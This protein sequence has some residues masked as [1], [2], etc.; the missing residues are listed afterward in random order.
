MPKATSSPT[1]TLTLDEVIRRLAEHVAVDGLLL[2]GSASE[3]ALIPASD[4]DLVVAL[5]EMPVP[6]HVGVTSIDRRLTDLLFVTTAQIE[7]ISALDAPVGAE[8][9][10]GRIIRWLQ[11]GQ[12]LFDREGRLTR[13]QQKVRTGVWVEDAG[14]GERYDGWFGINFNLAH[15]RRLLTADD[16]IYRMAADLRMVVYGAADLWFGYFRVRGLRWEGDKAAIRHVA[17]HDPAYLDLFMR[18]AGETNHERKFQ[19]YER[20]AALAT[21]PL[22]GLWPDHATALQLEPGTMRPDLID[23]ALRFWE[24]LVGD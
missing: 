24:E 18:F 23:A 3:A 13:A 15:L 4:Y 8:E 14:A 17:A 11:A 20:L 5:A 10:L 1:Q 21:A 22:G 9:W 19:L 6:L 16:P 2:I 7:E 12:I